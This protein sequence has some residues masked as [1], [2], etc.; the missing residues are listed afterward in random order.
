MRLTNRNKP[1]H[2][3]SLRKDTQ[4]KGKRRRD[5]R[6]KD[7]RRKGT[8]RKRTE[9]KRRR[10]THKS[11]GG[12][13]ESGIIMKEIQNNGKPSNTDMKNQCFW[14]SI[15]DW[16]ELKGRKLENG[17]DPTVRNIKESACEQTYK[18][19]GDNEQTDIMK[20]TVTIE[21]LKH[22]LHN[23]ESDKAI[24]NFAKKND[25]MI[26]VFNRD[27][28]TK[29]DIKAADMNKIRE[30]NL[31]FGELENID[32]QIWIAYSGGHFQ[33]ITK[34][35]NG[36][37]NYNIDGVT[38]GKA[39]T[40]TNKF[41]IYNNAGEIVHIDISDYV[42]NFI[43]GNNDTISDDLVNYYYDLQYNYDGNKIPGHTL[44][45]IILGL[46]T[47]EEA[48]DETFYNLNKALRD[49]I[50]KSIPSTLRGPQITNVSD[51]IIKSLKQ[52]FQGNNDDPYT[53]VAGPKATPVAAAAVARPKGGAVAVAPAAPVNPSSRL[54]EMFLDT[55][56]PHAKD[57]KYLNK[58]L[59]GINENSLEKV[60]TA[61]GYINQLINE[62]TD[63]L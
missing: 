37:I 8:Q 5:T 38:E 52:K 4:R 58:I 35:K 46:D 41:E 11:K 20:G 57:I 6:R 53:A 26:R 54:T 47:D 16:F 39:Y 19:N 62:H 18:C 48:H 23:Q 10:Y 15:S 33:L 51:S 55:I 61:S 34:Y 2:K 28:N 3:K 56:H 43:D 29:I 1:R 21:G 59:K 7:K 45:N 22:I 32:D 14:I 9:G 13:G 40:S 30:Y 60:T 27:T 17:R 44:I 50:E 49:G 25:V 36:K 63:V 12:A 42:K 31:D 24:K